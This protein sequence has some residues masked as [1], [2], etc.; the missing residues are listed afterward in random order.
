M[1]VGL[2]L[3]TSNSV[4]F[5]GGVDVPR[6]WPFIKQCCTL[7]PPR[8]R[9]LSHKQC[10]SLADQQ[11]VLAELDAGCYTRMQKH[12]M[13]LLGFGLRMLA[14]TEHAARCAASL[15]SL[16]QSTACGACGTWLAGPTAGSVLVNSAAL[17]RLQCM[18]LLPSLQLLW[19][20]RQRR[21]CLRLPIPF[22][23]AAPPRALSHTCGAHTTPSSST[24]DNVYYWCLIG[25]GP[26]LSVLPA[27]TADFDCITTDWCGRGRDPTDAMPWGWTP[28]LGRHRPWGRAVHHHPEACMPPKNTICYPLVHP[29]QRCS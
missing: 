29:A 6:A 3:A 28:L 5:N 16:K 2:Q 11:T 4:M 17:H 19:H 7:L 24:S 18:N 10:C 22:C 15:R 14:L 20:L 12:F 8:F 1:A 23:C 21:H 27:A 26:C 13:M 9:A 25:S